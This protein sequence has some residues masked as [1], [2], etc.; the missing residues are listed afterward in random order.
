MNA[1]TTVTFKS[2]FSAFDCSVAPLN[3]IA[4][5]MDY[6]KAPMNRLAHRINDSKAPINDVATWIYGS[7]AVMNVKNGRIDGSRPRIHGSCPV[8]SGSAAWI[9]HSCSVMNG[10]AAWMDHFWAK[11]CPAADLQTAPQRDPKPTKQFRFVESKKNDNMKKNNSKS[12]SEASRLTSARLIISNALEPP[13]MSERL[14][15]FG[16]DLTRIREGEALLNTAEQLIARHNK[17]Y[18]DQYAAT[19]A[20]K[21]QYATAR[22]SYIEHVRL[23]R[24]AKKKHST[25]E[26]SL[27]L[28][29]ERKNTISGWL[30]QASVFYVNA[31]TVPEIK[32]ALSFYGIDEAALKLGN[33][34]V[35]AVAAAL[36]EQKSLISVAQATTQEKNKAMAAL[37]NWVSDF[38]SI[39]RIALKDD[40]QLLE[41]FGIITPS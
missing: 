14:A 5:W 17:E 32:E 8:M 38:K 21:E 36:A 26:G 7:R 28:K 37:D 9:G 15:P 30:A 16:Y 23:A 20:L 40:A 39:A 2:L 19:E 22:E 10:S 11:K 6:N 27:Q 18:G 25:L 34:Q 1:Q 29:G 3:T 13:V 31:L 33:A 12:K 24:I 41:A 35:E 4:K